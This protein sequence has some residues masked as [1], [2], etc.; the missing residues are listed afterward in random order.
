MNV[1]LQNRRQKYSARA[2]VARFKAQALERR[3]HL[4]IAVNAHLS[5]DR[6][7]G[8]S[9]CSRMSDVKSIR[10]RIDML[11]RVIALRSESVARQ[12][13]TCK[14][15]MRACRQFSEAL[16]NVI[17]GYDVFLTERRIG[18]ALFDGG[19]YPSGFRPGSR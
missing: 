7:A 5:L 13:V 16:V 1:V 11:A 8:E 3:G 10:F 14:I 4:K 17:D 19:W 2:V 18:I 15:V 6:S 9:I 12:P